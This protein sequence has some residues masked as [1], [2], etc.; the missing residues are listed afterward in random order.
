MQIAVNLAAYLEGSA[1][2]MGALASGALTWSI[3][4]GEM[5]KPGEVTTGNP[6][7]GEHPEIRCGRGVE[8]WNVQ[9]AY[10]RIR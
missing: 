3:V 10:G 6:L 7:V 8:G 1:L 4:G 2:G 5:T 9:I